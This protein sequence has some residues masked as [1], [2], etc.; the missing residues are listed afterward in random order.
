M[1]V[2]LYFQWKCKSRDHIYLFKD[3]FRMC[4]NVGRT[5]ILERHFVLFIKDAAAGYVSVITVMFQAKFLFTF[6]YSMG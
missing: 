3:Y 5:F 4:L 6:G 2:C 1:L